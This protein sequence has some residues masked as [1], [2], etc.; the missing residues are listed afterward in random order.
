M[1]LAQTM[2]RSVFKRLLAMTR[3]AAPLVALALVAPLDAAL[4]RSSGGGN[5]NHGSSPPAQSHIATLPVKQPINHPII[6]QF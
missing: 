4:A 2:S 5:G 1:F 6:K 3:V